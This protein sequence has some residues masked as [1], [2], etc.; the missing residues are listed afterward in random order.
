MTVQEIKERYEDNEDV[1]TIE[2]DYE[3]D[4]EE[5]EDWLEFPEEVLEE[6]A[7]ARLKEGTLKIKVR[8]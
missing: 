6:Q 4:I 2:L 7:T 1:L 3:G 8:A 5:F